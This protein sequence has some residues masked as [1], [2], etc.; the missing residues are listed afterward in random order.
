MKLFENFFYGN[1]N[2]NKRPVNT[3]K[4][5]RDRL[6]WLNDE[7][8]DPFYYLKEDIKKLVFKASY[9]HWIKN[10]EVYIW[11]SPKK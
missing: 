2:V 4:L 1:G 5:A 6:L 7:N 3:A 10:V 11:N 9:P 8:R